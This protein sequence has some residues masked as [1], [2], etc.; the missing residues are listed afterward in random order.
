MKCGK[1][2]EE[3]QEGDE[4]I[5]YQF[6]RSATV[7]EE[8]NIIARWQHIRCSAVTYHAYWVALTEK[9]G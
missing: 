9:K 8:E 2:G 7:S 3:V 6:Y 5:P 1:C 4:I